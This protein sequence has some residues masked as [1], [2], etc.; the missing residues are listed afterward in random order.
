MTFFI[1][2]F[3]F[4][5]QK[6]LMTFLTYFGISS[7]VYNVF[8]KYWGDVSV[9]RPHL[10]LWGTAPSPPK[11]P[12]Y[13]CLDVFTIFQGSLYLAYCNLYSTHFLLNTVYIIWIWPIR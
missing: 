12:P 10:K 5:Q 2:K 6:F 8:P 3:Q 13:P 4:F 11:S 7:P 1:H 9:G